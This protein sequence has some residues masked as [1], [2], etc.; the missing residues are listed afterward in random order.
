MQKDGGVI[1]RVVTDHKEDRVIRRTVRFIGKKYLKFKKWQ[2]SEYSPKTNQIPCIIN[3]QYLCLNTLVHIFQARLGIP[4]T[5]LTIALGS[6]CHTPFTACH[7]L[8]HLSVQNSL[9]FYW[10]R[11]KMLIRWMYFSARYFV[12]FFKH[13]WTTSHFIFLPSGSPT[14]V[15]W[16][17]ECRGMGSWTAPCPALTEPLGSTCLK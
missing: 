11:E 1:I 12:W 7:T 10:F 13:C 9:S 8:C 6:Q 4:R 15:R 3:F 2:S 16:P 5:C 14:Q 17:H